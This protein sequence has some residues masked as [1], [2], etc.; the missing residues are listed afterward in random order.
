[1]DWV[2]SPDPPRDLDVLPDWDP[3]PQ[4]IDVCVTRA[5]G[6]L[7][8]ALE[9]KVDDVRF[10][11]WD[12]LKMAAAARIPF[13]ERAYLVVAAKTWD[14]ARS[15]QAGRRYFVGS[16]ALPAR[17]GWPQGIRATCGRSKHEAAD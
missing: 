10:T 7:R 15:K 4:S 6:A 3:K 1:L 14:S 2:S 17:G 8:L 13:V 11:F 9:L 12:M 5:D 16:P